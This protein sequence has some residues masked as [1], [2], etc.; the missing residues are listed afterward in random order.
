MFISQ[1]LE[2]PVALIGQPNKEDSA[3]KEAT[4]YYVK[5]LTIMLP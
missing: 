4:L 5:P 1:G 2:M 3:D